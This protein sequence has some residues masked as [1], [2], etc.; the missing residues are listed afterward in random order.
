MAKA[1]H[2]DYIKIVVRCSEIFVNIFYLVNSDIE[3][4]VL[5][6]KAKLRLGPMIEKNW[7]Y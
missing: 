4:A 6:S 5:N 3:I 7:G 1:V 2:C